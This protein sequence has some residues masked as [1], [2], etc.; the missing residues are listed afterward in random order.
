M[1]GTGQEE[2][3]EAALEYRQ[4]LFDETMAKAEEAGVQFGDDD[5]D[6]DDD[7]EEEDEDEE[8]DDDDE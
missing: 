3:L 4:K 6:D 2:V 5:D 7:I 8:E 1:S